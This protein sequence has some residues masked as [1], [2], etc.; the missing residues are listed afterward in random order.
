ME[1][2]IDGLLINGAGNCSD[3]PTVADAS[4]LAVLSHI[5]IL[6]SLSTTVCD[7][8]CGSA[9]APTLTPRCARA[10]PVIRRSQIEQRQGHGRVRAAPARALIASKA[11]AS[12]GPCHLFSASVDGGGAAASTRLWVRVKVP[13]QS[14]VF[15]FFSGFCFSF[16]TNG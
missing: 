16:S 1:P 10:G 4:V 6:R 15:F 3:R 5:K 14:R 12:G 2:P 13:S 8:V 7:S 11:G 9:G